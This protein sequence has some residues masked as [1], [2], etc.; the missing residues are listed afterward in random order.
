MTE[1]SDEI[2]TLSGKVDALAADNTKLLSAFEAY[3]AANPP[4]GE[5]AAA[6]LQALKDIGVKVDAV[7]AAD[8]A[9]DAKIEPAAPTPAPDAPPA[10]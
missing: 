9:E 3:V 6:E 4:S 10:S 1:L 7:D 5:N 2:T 8:Q